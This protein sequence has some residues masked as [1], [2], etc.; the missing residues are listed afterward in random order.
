M[1]KDHYCYKIPSV[2]NEKQCLPFFYRRPPIWITPAL[3]LHKKN[4]EPHFCDFSKISSPSRYKYINKEGL[5]PCAMSVV[6]LG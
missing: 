5:T 4:P 2:I 6:L 1:S 3:L